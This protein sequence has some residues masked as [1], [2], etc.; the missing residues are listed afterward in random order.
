MHMDVL[1][2]HMSVHSTCARS[3]WRPEEGIEF[4]TGVRGVCVC[5]ELSLD[6]LQKSLSWLSSPEIPI[7]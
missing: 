1:S 6:P 3:L 2:G 4:G 7:S 5:W